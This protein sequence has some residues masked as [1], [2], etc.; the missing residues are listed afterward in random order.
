MIRFDPLFTLQV[1]HAFYG[2]PSEDFAFVLPEESRQVARRGRIL[3]KRVGSVLHGLFEADAAGAPMVSLVGQ[4]LRIGLKL[5]NPAFASFTDPAPPVAPAI[6]HYRNATAPGQF[7]APANRTLVGPVFAHTLKDVERPVTVTLKNAVGTAVSTETVT[8]ANDRTTVSFDVTGAPPGVYSLEESYPAPPVESTP[9]FLHSELQQ[10]GV[11]GVVELAIG[12]GFYANAP[13]FQIAFTA[14]QETWKYYVVASNYSN[15]EF[16]QLGVF[17]RGFGEDSRPEIGFTKVAAADFTAAEL[18]TSLLGAPDAKVVL[19]KSQ[20][21]V[22]RRQRAR[23]KI[24][25]ERNGE[26]V[27]ENLPQPGAQKTDAN[28]IIHLSK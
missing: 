3:V 6:V 1:S 18:P 5:V 17:D 22:T 7:D 10:E 2:G 25:L 11:V 8:A 4:P 28:L 20:A 26:V 27:V 24:Q 16:S 14:R 13:A 23:K 21:E 19:F 15:Q 12:A 9:Y